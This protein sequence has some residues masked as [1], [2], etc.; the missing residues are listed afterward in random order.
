MKRAQAVVVSLFACS[1][2]FGAPGAMATLPSGIVSGLEALGQVDLDGISG[3]DP[4]LSDKVDQETTLPFTRSIVSVADAQAGS[5]G[6]FEYAASADISGPAMKVFGTFTG[7]SSAVG[8][9][10]IPI[11]RVAAQ[12]RDVVTLQSSLPEYK[13]T[14]E[15]QVDGMISSSSSSSV[16]FANASL[17]FGSSI[18][19]DSA[20][21]GFGPVD[22]RLSIE[23]TIS[24]PTIDLP[25]DAELSFVISRVDVGDTVTGD[26]ANTATLR[27]ILPE[28]GVTLVSSASGTFAAPIPEPEAYALM[29][30]GL[31]LVGAAAHRRAR[32]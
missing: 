18:F 28:S 7:G 14:L 9:V 12:V 32:A 31:A 4:M 22:R 16:A 23:R 27:L 8:N 5:F 24:E 13:V 30:V 17:E 20:F 2:C 3:T 10:E 26:L 19:Q 6:S 15:L 1:M 29:L 21:F 25:L 11:M